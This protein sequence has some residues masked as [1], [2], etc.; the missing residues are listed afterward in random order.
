MDIHGPK[1]WKCSECL[2]L[3]SRKDKLREHMIGQHNV[4]RE[5]VDEYLAA[6][7]LKIKPPAS[8]LTEIPG[9]EESLRKQAST[10]DGFQTPGKKRNGSSYGYTDA[11]DDAT[12]PDVSQNEDCSSSDT[13]DENSGGNSDGESGGGGAGGAGS[14]GRYGVQGWQTAPRFDPNNGTGRGE[15]SNSD[16]TSLSTIGSHQSLSTVVIWIPHTLMIRRVVG[17]FGMFGNTKFAA[18]PRKNSCPSFRD[19]RV[20]PDKYCTT[21]ITANISLRLSSPSLKG[22]QDSS[23]PSEDTCFNRVMLVELSRG[24]GVELA[25][26]LRFSQF[27]RIPI[28]IQEQPGSVDQDESHSPARGVLEGES[29]CIGGNL[30]LA[31]VISKDQI[32]NTQRIEADMADCKPPTTSMPLALS[33][34]DL[35]GAGL[36]FVYVIIPTV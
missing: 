14:L 2:Y 35:K 16:S 36:H 34:A 27:F 26:D 25:L 20:Y 28:Q 12:E 5:E 4:S 8:P 29:D 11:S 17:Y 3:S 15:R 23:D 19:I 31:D 21:I 24:S 1:E 33:V 6:L 10:A 13:E 9:I 32:P 30:I 22:L 7:E 18:L